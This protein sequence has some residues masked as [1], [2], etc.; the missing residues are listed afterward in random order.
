ML[1]AGSSNSAVSSISSD[2]YYIGNSI[3]TPP[4]DWMYFSQS[5]NEVMF[6]V[7]DMQIMLGTYAMTTEEMASL[8][9]LDDESLGNALTLSTQVGL[10][11]MSLNSSAFSYYTSY[12]FPASPVV[13]FSG[14]VSAVMGESMWLDGAAMLTDTELAMVMVFSDGTDYVSADGLRYC[15]VEMFIYE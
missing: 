3:I 15:G 9:T 14:D 8:R 7:Y 4:E 2:V 1:S 5:E 12:L 10:D 13:Y 11:G 6:Y